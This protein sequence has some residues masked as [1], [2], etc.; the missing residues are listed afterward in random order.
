MWHGQQT[1]GALNC[2]KGNAF[3]DLYIYSLVPGMFIETLS[4]LWELCRG[5]SVVNEMH[6]CEE[7][8][9]SDSERHMNRAGATNHF[10][11][12]FWEQIGYLV[13]GPL[14]PMLNP[15]QVPVSDPLTSAL[16][17]FG[18]RV[19]MLGGGG[20]TFRRNRAS[21]GQ[22]LRA[23]APG[24]QNPTPLPIGHCTEQVPQVKL[25]HDSSCSISSL[26][27]HQLAAHPGERY[28]PCPL[29][30]QLSH[31]RNY[32]QTVQGHS[33]TRISRQDHH[34]VLTV[35]SHIL[36]LKQYRLAQPLCKND[37]QIYEAFH[38][39][40]LKNQYC[41]ND[42][43]IQSNLQVQCNPNQIANDILQRIRIYK[44]T[45]CMET[46][47]TMNSQSNLEK[48]KRSWRKQPS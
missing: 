42:Y 47:K 34:R 12:L 43:T 10:W 1:F 11:C 8:S 45:I 21:M 38:I 36:K 16:L 6:N 15:C 18:V 25:D 13:P 35:A 4:V 41:Q 22:K 3:M 14:Q 46:Q 48:E 17:P 2:M 32:E 23:Y 44:F 39:F 37:M 26:T 19:M 5:N 27:S 29:Q 28:D 9:D 7:T 40:D 33:H 30:I 31:Q 20:H 24:T